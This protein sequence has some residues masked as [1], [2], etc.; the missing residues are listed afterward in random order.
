MEQDLRNPGDS[1][2]GILLFS[3]FFILLQAQ[4][5]QLTKNYE[6]LR[7]GIHSKSRFV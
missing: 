2:G 7:D 1:W 6:Q 5:I 4:K 3:Q